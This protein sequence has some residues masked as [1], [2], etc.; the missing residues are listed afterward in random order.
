[1]PITWNFL[2][3]LW[4][5]RLEIC[6]RL[7]SWTH[8]WHTYNIEYLLIQIQIVTSLNGWGRRKI[9]LKECNAKCRHLKKLPVK[10]LCGRCL[11][12]WGPEPHN[13][14]TLHTVHVYTVYLF[15]KGRGRR[16][17]P[18]RRL[19]VQTFTKLGRKYQQNWLYLQSIN[20]DKHLPQDLFTGQFFLDDD[21]L[22]WCLYS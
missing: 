7:N 20:S 11:T 16:V 9:R 8:H 4:R 2:C 22:L 19:E 3:R 1:M 18:E 15:T 21:I 10:G 13:A 12:V 14:P 5:K 6:M 17:E